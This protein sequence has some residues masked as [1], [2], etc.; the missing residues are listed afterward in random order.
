MTICL[1]QVVIGHTVL[2]EKV[3]LRYTSP[4]YFRVD[5][6]LF[7]DFPSHFVQ[8]FLLT[9]RLQLPNHGSQKVV[10]IAITPIITTLMNHMN[11]VYDSP[12][13][14]KLHTCYECEPTLQ[15]I[16]NHMSIFCCTVFIRNLH[17]NIVP[18][19][20]VFPAL[21]SFSNSLMGRA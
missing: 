4:V 15:H 3:L 19:E 5:P 9:D 2:R 13:S 21:N 12:S 10:R 8:L 14:W 11:I 1:E 6:P 20:T 7:F 16:S 18:I 17:L